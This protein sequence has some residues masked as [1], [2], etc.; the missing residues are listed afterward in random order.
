MVAK[1]TTAVEKWTAAKRTQAVN[2]PV[3]VTLEAMSE[4]EVKL[5]EKR[6][7]EIFDKIDRN[8]DG[9]IDVNEVIAACRS[10]GIRVNQ[11]EAN[12]MINHVRNANDCGS[13]SRPIRFEE[14]RDFL[15]R[16]P[17][18]DYK[19]LI[20]IWRHSTFINIGEDTTVPDDFSETE[21][22]TG[23]WWRHLLAGGVAGAVSRTCTAPLDRIK[24]FLQ[25]RGAEFGSLR[26]CFKHMY[27]EGGYASFWRGNGINVLKIAPETALKFMAYEQA[28]RF[29]RGNSNRELSI[30][31]R[32]ISG[33]FAGAMSQTVI[34]PLEVLKT[35]LCLRST[36]QF[37]GILDATKKIYKHERL[38]AFYKG[39][40]PNLLGIIPYA[41]IDLAIYETLKK[42][43]LRTHSQEDNPGVLVLLTCGTISSS[44][45]QLASYP[46]ALV[47]TRLQAQIG[48]HRNENMIS[49]FRGILD[50]EGFFGLYRGITPNFMK[51]APA[52]SISY[53]VYEYTRR[54]LGATMS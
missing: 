5:K 51:V 28:K 44:C 39:Y 36:G 12:A 40:I 24:V 23:M 26:L 15:L 31:E 4:K 54:A 41:G 9:V 19:D 21:L 32:F 42:W 6:L 10:I 53:V 2:G 29:I 35:R 38:K 8:D 17:H 52:V 14:W 27:A 22:D 34:Y 3:A 18:S 30:S 49:V 43:Y 20:Q 11:E 7:K 33:S 50:R 1:A 48:V 13:D 37:D 16:F 45:G 46:L 25:V 47:R